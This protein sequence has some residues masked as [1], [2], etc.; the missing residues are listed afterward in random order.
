MNNTYHRPG[1]FK[2]LYFAVLIFHGSTY[3]WSSGEGTGTINQKRNSPAEENTVYATNVKKVLSLSAKTAPNQDESDSSTTDQEFNQYHAYQN[4]H[5]HKPTKRQDIETSV[6]NQMKHWFFIT[7]FSEH[8]RKPRD[9]SSV[10]DQHDHTNLTCPSY[11]SCLGAR[12]CTTEID[13]GLASKDERCYC[14][15]YCEMFQDCCADYAQACINKSRQP[16]TSQV[17]KGLWQCHRESNSTNRVWMISLC[18]ATNSTPDDIRENCSNSVHT[19]LKDSVPVKDTKGITYKN[20]FC[21]L[22]HGIPEHETQFFNAELSC[23]GSVVSITISNTTEHIYSNCSYIQWKIPESFPRRYCL[24]TRGNETCLLQSALL[25]EKCS[26]SIPGIVRNWRVK[27]HYYLNQYCA[28]C[29]NIS[30]NDIKCGSYIIRRRP[31]NQSTYDDVIAV[32]SEEVT[33]QNIVYC[34]SDKV[35]DIITRECREFFDIEFTPMVPFAFRYI[36]VVVLRSKVPLQQSKITYLKEAIRSDMMEKFIIPLSINVRYENITVYY[37]DITFLGELGPHSGDEFNSTVNLALSFNIT[38]A[39]NSFTTMKKTWKPIFCFKIETYKPG[40]Y[41]F[42]SRYHPAVYINSTG[43]VILPDNYFGEIDQRAGKTV[44]NGSMILDPEGDIQ[45][46]RRSQSISNCSGV[47]IGLKKHEYVILPK[48]SLYRNQTRESMDFLMLNGTAYICV[49][50]SSYYNTRAK[51]A[52]TSELLN[53]LSFIGLCV[54]IP[55]LLFVL[56]TYSL[57]NELRTVPGVNLMNLTFSLLLTHSLMLGIKVTHI[58]PLCTAI[59]VL[60]HYLYLVTFTWMSV[61]AFDTYRTFSTTCYSRQRAR[62]CKCRFIA[63]G[64][65]P[66]FLFVFTCFNLDISGKVAIGY[67][68]REFC[69]IGNLRLNLFVFV[70]P[71][72][73]LVTFNVLVFILIVYSIQKV[74]KQTQN[75]FNSLKNQTSVWLFVKLAT[76]MGFT[77]IFGFLWILWSDYFAYPFVIFTS[78]QGVY[79]MVAFVFTPRIKNMYR[80]LLIAKEAEP[81]ETYDTRL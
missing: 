38:T 54:S 61:I 28:L 33:Q 25:R 63:L 13:P 49:H 68:D 69:W 19:S 10:T 7:S 71:V 16:S 32:N 74:K 20:R 4:K 44:K 34:G 2:L 17:T 3:S 8:H 48:G 75:V 60:L 11:V 14:E 55:C 79:I 59:A 45:V 27:G 24:K 26:S 56:F 5:E 6:L 62:N 43:D 46:C 77:W 18:P 52:E 21:A 67:G 12:N 40:E 35:Y 73:F 70:I 64:W 53:L 31:P 76:L 9:T 78:L 30:F 1:R 80:D 57:F 66:A 36:A 51:K 15:K 29:G 81:V 39:N 42:V 23:N 47:F 65:L 72:A 50:Y 22:C 58:K 41:A 37:I